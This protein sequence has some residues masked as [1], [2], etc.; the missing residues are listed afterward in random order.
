MTL[1]FAAHT[2]LCLS[3]Q[4]SHAYLQMVTVLTFLLC[5]EREWEEEREKIEGS[6]Q[7]LYFV[8]DFILAMQI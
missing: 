1:F 6:D 7:S 2:E 3:N 8:C 4:F 5:W